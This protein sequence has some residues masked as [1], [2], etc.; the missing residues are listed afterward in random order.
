MNK[1]KQLYQQLREEDNDLKALGISTKIIREERVQ[2]FEDVWLSK[3]QEKCNVRHDPTSNRYTFELNGYG[4]M[5]FYPKANK[6]LIR[7]LN[8]WQQPG[9]QWLIK[10]FNLN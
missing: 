6:L 5:D 7:K 10:E 4:V 9:L 3:L 2:K 8:K 1:K